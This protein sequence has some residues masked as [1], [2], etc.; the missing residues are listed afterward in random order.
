MC[1]S[2]SRSDVVFLKIFFNVT[3]RFRLS[4]GH[5]IHTIFSIDASSSSSP[6]SISTNVCEQHKTSTQHISV[7]TTGVRRLHAMFNANI[8]HKQYS[9]LNRIYFFLSGLPPVP[10][11]PMLL[12]LFPYFVCMCAPSCVR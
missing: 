12:L 3:M 6:R 2:R 9:T 10:F 8:I 4:A 11:F 5:S 7:H 1:R